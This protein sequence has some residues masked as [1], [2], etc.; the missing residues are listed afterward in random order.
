MNV[1]WRIVTG[2]IGFILVAFFLWHFSFIVVW[3]LIAGVISLI[4]RP[5]TG[6]ICKIKIGKFSL[7]RNFGA[8]ATIILLIGIVTGLFL[9]FIPILF[10]EAQA[11]SNI[12]YSEFETSID[13]PLSDVEDFLIEYDLLDLGDSQSFEMYLWENIKGFLQNNQVTKIIGDSI[14]IV[15]NVLYAFLA[16]TFITFFF[17]REP[18]LFKSIILAFIPDKYEDRVIKVLNRTKDTLTNYA[19]ALLAQISIIFTLMAIG[20]S[21][22]G[23]LGIGNI[24]FRTAILIAAFAGII[25]LIPYLGPAMGFVFGSLIIFIT[26]LDLIDSPAFY[27]LVVAVLI[28]YAITQGVD[29]FFTQPVLFGKSVHA[30]PL[31]IFLVIIIAGNLAGVTGMILGVP[32]YSFLRIFLNEFFS[33]Y[34]L[35]QS[36]TASMNEGDKT[37]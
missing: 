16:V 35:I 11:L 9:I 24:P 1:N 23:W 18:G 17:L 26:N 22:I 14:G 32:T 4:G 15:G 34:K 5:I 13:K 10:S 21:I 31:E 30:H 20:L 37:S 27:T 6:F 3:I 28:V 33:E 25:N 19:F 8:A 36:L 7:G 12:D 2:V 29:N